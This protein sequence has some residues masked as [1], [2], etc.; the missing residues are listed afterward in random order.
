[1][2]VDALLLLLGSTFSLMLIGAVFAAFTCKE[3]WNGSD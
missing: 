2:I 3:V 1:M